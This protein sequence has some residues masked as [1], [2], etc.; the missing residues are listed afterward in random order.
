MCHNNLFNDSN[1]IFSW[2]MERKEE[3]RKPKMTH[4]KKIIN[5]KINS[6]WFEQKQFVRSSVIIK[7]SEHSL[8]YIRRFKHP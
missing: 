7:I 8:L 1:V 3:E 2:T 6:L 5:L 4:G